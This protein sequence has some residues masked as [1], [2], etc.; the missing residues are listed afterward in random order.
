M[1][2]HIENRKHKLAASRFDINQ[3]RLLFDAAVN[4]DRSGLAKVLVSERTTRL[5]C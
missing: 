5:E 4:E 1:S 2:R 3:V